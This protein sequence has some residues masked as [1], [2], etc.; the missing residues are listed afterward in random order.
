MAHGASSAWANDQSLQFACA[1]ILPDNAIQNN[2]GYLFLANFRLFSTT[3]AL[4]YT[5]L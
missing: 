2:F 4:N 1:V 3:D 5:W